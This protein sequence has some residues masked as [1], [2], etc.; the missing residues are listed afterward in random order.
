MVWGGPRPRPHCSLDSTSHHKDKPFLTYYFLPNVLQVV[1]QC[2][3][4]EGVEPEYIKTEVLPEFFKSFWNRRMALDRCEGGRCSEHQTGPEGRTRWRG[5]GIQ[6]CEGLGG[7]VWWPG[8]PVV[9]GFGRI[10]HVRVTMSL[11]TSTHLAAI[12]PPPLRRNYK[13]LVETTVELAN[14]VGSSEIVSRVVED[15]KD[16]SEPYRRMVMETID[17]VVS[18]LGSSDIDARL[19]ELLIDGILFAFQEQVGAASV[20]CGVYLLGA[21]GCAMPAICMGFRGGR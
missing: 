15:L 16:E 8:V 13:A 21:G 2:V 4:T 20:E 5:G 6:C 3:G 1:K 18:A 12:P 17:K 11:S 9:R 19:E 14:K 10:E 7:G